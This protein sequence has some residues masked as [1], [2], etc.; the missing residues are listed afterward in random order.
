MHNQIVRTWELHNQIILPEL[1]NQP[2]V[3]WELPNQTIITKVLHNHPVVTWE[4]Q[5]ISCNLGITQPN[6]L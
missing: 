2:V 4:I 1:Q 3:K 5:P 6:R